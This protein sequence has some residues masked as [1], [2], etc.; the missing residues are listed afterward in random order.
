MPNLRRSRQFWPLFM[1]L[2]ILVSRCSGHQDNSSQNTVTAEVVF[3]CFAA[4]GIPVVPSTP[5]AG[6]T[7]LLVDSDGQVLDKLLT[8]EKGEV[9]KNVTVAVDKKYGEKTT[10]TMEQPRGTVTLIA[11][12]EGYRE[13]VVYEV[14]ISKGSAAQPFYMEPIVYGERNEPAVMLGNNHHLEVL[15]LVEEYAPYS[16]GA[17]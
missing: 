13:S 14:P 10:P 12:K 8:D 2:L 5:L 7:I 1:V 9:Q 6:V 17:E 15:T 3:R 16:I 11:F 4:T